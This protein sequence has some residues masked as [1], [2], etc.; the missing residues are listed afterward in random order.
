MN[1]PGDQDGSRNTYDLTSEPYSVNAGKS[2]NLAPVMGR[3]GG[4]EQGDNDTL[5]LD[6]IGK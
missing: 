5:S 6:V 2:L 3:A 4:R 1:I